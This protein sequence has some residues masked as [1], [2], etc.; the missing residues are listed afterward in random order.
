MISGNIVDLK[1]YIDAK[2]AQLIISFLEELKSSDMKIGEWI[3]LSDDLKVL[4]LDKSNYVKGVYE[5]H[6][7]YKDVHIVIKGLDTLHF[8]NQEISN[9]SK[10]YDEQADYSLFNSEDLFSVK[11]LPNSFTIINQN[12][13]HTNQI[14]DSLTLKLVAKIN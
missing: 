5:A 7:V 3:F 12:E 6:K 13:Q 11:L 14:E 1:N 10:V 2:K 9:E 8:A 4:L